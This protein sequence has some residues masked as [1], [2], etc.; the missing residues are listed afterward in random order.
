MF[1][2]THEFTTIIMK[3]RTSVAL[4]KYLKRYLYKCWCISGD[5]VFFIH[6]FMREREHENISLLIF[7][8][9]WLENPGRI[10][11]NYVIQNHRGAILIRVYHI[12]NM[13]KNAKWV[14][15]HM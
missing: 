9:N 5:F 8:I 14:S 10:D 15:N 1:T 7:D 12:T 11:Y 3:S 13:S 4:E 6:S 2:T